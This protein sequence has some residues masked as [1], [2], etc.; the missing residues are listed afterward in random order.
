[1]LELGESSVG[2]LI[3][4]AEVASSKIYELLDKLIE[5]GLV[6]TFI[7][8][9]TKYFKAVNP[10]RLEEYF[11][12]KIKSL[13]A[14]KKELDNI[15]PSLISVFET[16]KKETEV[17][18]FNGYKGIQTAFYEIIGELKKGDEL[19][20]IGGGDKPTT[21]ENTQLFFEQIHR[22]RADKGIILKIIFSE[23]RR[24]SYKLMRTF[25]HTYAKFLPFGT[26]STINIYKDVTILLV[27]SPTPAAIRIKD[28]QITE[29]Y[30]KYFKQMWK[31]AKK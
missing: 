22:K 17:E 5:K 9:N 20:V 8:A 6:T 26:T 30:R 29:S 25:A 7:E 21:N 31:L 23:A 14:D 15:L 28:K 27:M 18:L 19:L 11:N 2:A 24:K 12:S 1:L 13:E 10:Q 16:H 3:K 4:K